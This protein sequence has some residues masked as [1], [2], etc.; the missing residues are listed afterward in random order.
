[1]RGFSSSR[2]HG[3]RSSKVGCRCPIGASSWATYAL[4]DLAMAI[5]LA[6]GEACPIA[7]TTGL[8][9]I[10]ASKGTIVIDGRICMVLACCLLREYRQAARAAKSAPVHPKADVIGP[11]GAASLGGRHRVGTGDESIT[12]APAPFQPASPLRSRTS[13]ITPRR[14]YD[15]AM[16]D[17]KPDDVDFHEETTDPPVADLHNFCKVE[18]WTRDGTTVDSLLY[19][20]NSLGRACSVFAQPSSI[21]RA[22]D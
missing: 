5:A 17:P 14:V 13:F 4:D 22:S 16:P 15:R 2:S 3:G 8:T 21:G 18:K 19:A 6:S 12:M 9:S 20:G 7:W 10:V 11:D 1:V